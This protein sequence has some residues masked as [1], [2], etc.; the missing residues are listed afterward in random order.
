VKYVAD[1]QR[2]FSVT[3]IF[4]DA[5]LSTKLHQLGQ[6]AELCDPSGKVLGKFVPLIDL[7]EWEPVTPE[8]SEEELDRRERA[9]EK[10]Y[11]TQEVLDHLE[12]L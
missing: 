6:P 12:R 8:A 2:S 5:N 7:S 9:G 10:R 1:Q 3:Q 11:S 4:L